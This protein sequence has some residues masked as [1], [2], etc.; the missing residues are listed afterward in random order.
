MKNIHHLAAL[1]LALI[2]AGG[3]ISE[4]GAQRRGPTNVSALQVDENA[5]GLSDGQILSHRSGHRSN[6]SAIN[7]QL[8]AA[9]RNAIKEQIGALREGGASGEDISSILTAELT[10]AGVELPQSFTDQAAAREAQ[11]TARQ[12]QR[13]VIQSLVESMTADGATR[14]EIRQVLQDADY[15]EPQRSRRGHRSGPR[16]QTAPDSDE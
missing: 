1:A 15:E 7:A 4:T 6:R 11:R 12:A 9:Q 3:A 13:E 8:T 5:D 14:A 16:P 10:A 2:V